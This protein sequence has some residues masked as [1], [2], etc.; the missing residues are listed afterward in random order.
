MNRISSLYLVI[1]ALAIGCT[2][3]KTAA[4]LVATEKPWLTASATNIQVETISVPPP[5]ETSTMF[6]NPT[7]TVT[8]RP[9]ATS[10]LTP[11][12]PSATATLT[13]TPFP[14]LGEAERDQVLEEYMKTNGNC[15]LPC[16]W[17]F[18]S[19]EI[20]WSDVR[21]FLQ[22][23]NL[24]ITGG[25][26][27]VD[28]T[29]GSY[30][31][32][33]TL[34]K[35]AGFRGSLGF[36][37]REDQKVQ[38]IGFSINDLGQAPYYSARNIMKDL[39][40][41]AYIGVELRIGG[42]TGLTNVASLTIQ[43]A[44]EEN[45]QTPW[46]ERPW[47]LFYYTGGAHKSGTRYRFCPIDLGISDPEWPPDNFSLSLQSPQAALTVDELASLSGRPHFDV[48]SNIEAAT[49]VSVEDVYN[50]ML[51]NQGQVCFDTPIDFW[52]K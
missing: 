10:A 1:L 20:S 15:V 3:A 37:V 26:F 28:G 23:M 44:Y 41:P 11:L 9:A 21:V 8:A 18:N 46:L 47:A 43:I 52:T 32:P 34:T 24:K 27:H 42:P 40:V 14:T 19:G 35:N 50:R 13:L 30:N 36:F 12:P 2:P 51:E 4:R 39:G 16:F 25:P 7:Y 33:F 5:R 29:A 38:L 17:G 48:L 6:P 31:A 45:K 22:H 49:G